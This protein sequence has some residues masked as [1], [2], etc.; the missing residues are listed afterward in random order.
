MLLQTDPTVIYGMGDS[1]H[2]NI[3]SKDLTTAT[4]YN[5]YV[6]SGLPPTPIAMPGRAAIYAVL[7][8]E[9]GNN[10]YFVAR[11]DGTHVFSATLKEHNLAVDNF[12]RKKK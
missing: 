12:Q 3:K 10:I 9:S 6:I 8:P 5:T 1:Y 4:P 2:G 7:H 11:G